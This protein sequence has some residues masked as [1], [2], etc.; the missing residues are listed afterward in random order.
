MSKSKDSSVL[1]INLLR[2][3]HTTCMHF[4]YAINYSKTYNTWYKANTIAI[5][6]IC[7]MQGLKYKFSTDVTF[8]LIFLI[9]YL[10]P[11]YRGHLLNLVPSL[12][13]RKHTPC[14]FIA[15]DSA[16]HG[17]G[18]MSLLMSS[19]VSSALWPLAVA[20]THLNLETRP[21]FQHVLTVLRTHEEHL[22][23]RNRKPG[24][25]EEQTQ[26][27]VGCHLPVWCSGVRV[28]LQQNGKFLYG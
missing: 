27:R 10:N 8:S 28:I 25:T 23:A 22:G 26:A 16:L 9:H 12:F 21:K 2:N 5:T 11:R 19:M 6:V 15:F 20:H 1:Y 18:H 3:L 14:L 17:P 24:K 4:L 7:I 13:N